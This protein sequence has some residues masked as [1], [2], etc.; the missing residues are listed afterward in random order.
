MIIFVFFFFFWRGG[1]CIEQH[2]ERL[3]L[4]HADLKERTRPQTASWPRF[5][6]KGLERP[7]GPHIHGAPPP[8]WPR[9]KRLGACTHGSQDLASRG[10]KRL[11]LGPT[12]P[13]GFF[14]GSPSKRL[15]DKRKQ[16][17]WTTRSFPPCSPAG[18]LS[19]PRRPQGLAPPSGP[20]S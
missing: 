19:A 8:A 14:L 5:F 11:L 15:G 10:P 2:E 18:G 1:V 16:G 7:L 12:F 20:A 3:D 13:I 17:Y 6:P 4:S 9:P